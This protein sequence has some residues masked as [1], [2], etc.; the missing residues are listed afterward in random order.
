MM[1]ICKGI[2]VHS[3]YDKTLK[4]SGTEGACTIT[5]I[6]ITVSIITVSIITFSMMTLSIMKF[7]IMTLSITTLRKKSFSITINN[8]QP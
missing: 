6:I 4:R 1:G 2:W 7:S 5:L 3:C 8:T